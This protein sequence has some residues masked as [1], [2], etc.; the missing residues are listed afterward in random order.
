MAMAVGG[1]LSFR[2]MHGHGGGLPDQQ[3]PSLQFFLSFFFLDPSSFP[4]D[5]I[6]LEF[7]IA[8]KKESEMD[9]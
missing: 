8:R 1:G 7:L 5:R 3:T 6:L 4:I 9:G 2:F